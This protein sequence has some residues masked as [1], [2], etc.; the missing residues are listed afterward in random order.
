MCGIAGLISLNPEPQVGAMLQSIEHRGRDDEGV[1]TSEVI[2]DQGARVTLGHRRLA[3]IDTS[4]AGHQ[5]MF[6]ADGRYVI[7]FGGEIYNYRELRE[8]LRSKGYPFHTETDTEV[9]LTAFAEWGTNCLQRL[10]GM[11][12][13]A[14]WD[15]EKRTLTLARDRVGIKPLYY[16]SIKGT[17]GATDSFAFASEVKA[18]L[19]T[20]LVRASLNFEALNQYL[21]FLWTPDPHTLFENIWKLPPGHFLTVQDGRIN[22]IEWWDISFDEIA[23]GRSESWWR[24]RVLETLDRVVKLEMVADVPLGSFLSG[25]VDSSSIVALMKR[26]SNG[27]SVSTY[28][29]GMAAEDLHYDIVPDDVVWARR[30]SDLLQTDYHEIML[31]AD[32][33]TLLPK[34]IYHAD[35]PLADPAMLSSFLISQ[36]ARE[37]LKVML[38]GMGGDEVFAGYP[39]HMAMRIAGALDPAPGFLRRP[40]MNVIADTLP[41]GRPGKLTGPLRNAKKFARSAALDFEDRYLGFGTYF[42]PEMKQ[43]IFTEET[44]Q[45]TSGMDAYREHRRYFA[46]VKNADPLNQ[47][48]YVDLKTFLPCLN[49]AYTD[50]TSMAANLEV[51]VPFLN[52]ELMDLAARMPP[53]LKLR[54]LKRKYI[55]KRAAEKLLPKDVVWR[56]KAGFGA[57]IRAWLRG[58]LKPLV[59]D[60]L[61]EE[62]VRRR[63]LFRP[64]AVRQIIDANLSGRE[65]FPL[66]VFQLLTLELW[67]REFMDKLSGGSS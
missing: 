7:T 58:P 5:P 10:N 21:T 2:D 61:S 16:S 11:F 39:R 27:K 28:T 15:N 36:A 51:R 45:A 12:A 32:V 59:E 25:G 41:G 60:L 23:E 48:L 65:D 49:L 6:S 50:K 37:T 29:V 1:W 44:Q 3:I 13:F 14:V 4:S 17:S 52:H 54:G 9:L 31:Q 55:L 26:H 18:I 46:R 57:P 19:A 8:E 53:N 20:G 35:E 67:Q 38:S 22:L 33:A 34:L 43:Q 40:L 66:Q 62:T 63:G 56:K 30:V 64:A 47:L 24:D 42:T